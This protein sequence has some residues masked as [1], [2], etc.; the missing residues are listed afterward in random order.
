MF[1]P[2]GDPEKILKLIYDFESFSS[3]KELN[4]IIYIVTKLG[5]SFDYDVGN[6][7]VLLDGVKSRGE[8]SWDLFH[9]RKG[10]YLQTHSPVKLLSKG[11]ELLMRTRISDVNFLELRDKLLQIDRHLWPKV[12]A[13]LYLYDYYAGD[14]EKIKFALQEGF[15]TSEKEI[16]KISN[17]VP[18]L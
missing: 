17:F 4:T 5:N 10:G 16:E 15:E 2:K 7:E 11:E 13:F 8:V 12:A 3:V 14:M 1:E 18:S 9:L 6:F